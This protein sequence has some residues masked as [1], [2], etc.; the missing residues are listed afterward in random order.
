MDREAKKLRKHL[1]KHREYAELKARKQAG[2][3]R[4]NF[5]KDKG[6]AGAQRITED[7]WESLLDQHGHARKRP[8][9]TELM[10]RLHLLP[11]EVVE[12]EYPVPG[13]HVSRSLVE[14]TI[15]IITKVEHV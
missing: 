1:E 2:K 5:K 6:D 15:M 9:L 12:D 4:K 8:S 7:N 14:F 10:A 11:A 3:L 13:F